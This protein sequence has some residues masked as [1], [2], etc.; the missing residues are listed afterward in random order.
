MTPESTPSRVLNI[1]MLGSSDPRG[2]GAA[3][4]GILTRAQ[5]DYPDLETRE[6]MVQVCRA[7]WRETE[8]RRAELVAAIL[9]T[10]MT[11][12]DVVVAESCVMALA[13]EGEQ[14]LGA[15]IELLNYEHAGMRNMAFLG[16]GFLD[17]SSRWALPQLLHSL[18]EQ[19]VGSAKAEIVFALGRV[20]GVEAKAALSSLVEQLKWSEKKDLALLDWAQDALAKC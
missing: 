6:G 16:F 4:Y 5:S 20:G 10:L 8:S 13:T 14:G 2:P 3:A 18:S 9:R 1:E 11:Y 7:E 19:P 15:L 17:R 12:R